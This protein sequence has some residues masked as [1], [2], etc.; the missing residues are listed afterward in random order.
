MTK[1]LAPLLLITL[2]IFSPNSWAKEHS[3]GKPH[4]IAEEGPKKTVEMCEAW[5]I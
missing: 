5:A 4:P 2:F 1:H 3:K